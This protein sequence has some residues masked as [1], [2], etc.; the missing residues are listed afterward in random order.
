[1][2]HRRKYGNKVFVADGLTFDSKKEYQRWEVLQEELK[3]GEISELRRQ[4]WFVL[5]DG[6]EVDGV[7]QRPIRYRADFVYNRNGVEVVED[8]KGVRTEVF[9]LKEK[10]F[11]ARYGKRILV[12]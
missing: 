5:L 9:R 11:A 3:R 8:V 7:R 10:M 4:V 6:C 2:S 12:T 1:M